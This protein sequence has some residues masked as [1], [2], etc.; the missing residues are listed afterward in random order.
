MEENKPE[1]LEIEKEEPVKTIE[2]EAQLML[3]DDKLVTEEEKRMV[4]NM[5]NGD[6]W[7]HVMGSLVMV[8]VIRLHITFIRS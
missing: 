4:K 8:I 1:E 7:N 2:A 6:A 3:E 5:S